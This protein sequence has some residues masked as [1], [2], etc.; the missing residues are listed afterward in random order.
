MLKIRLSKT[1]KK[2]APS[3]RIVVVPDKH[4]RN[5]EALEVLGFFNPGVKPPAF[6]LNKERLKYWL[7]QGARMTES[8]KRLV[9][10][11]YTFKPYQPEKKEVTTG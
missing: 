4:P 9:E 11:K 6:S 7:K 3:Y 10:G 1:G 2:N 8:V 5:G